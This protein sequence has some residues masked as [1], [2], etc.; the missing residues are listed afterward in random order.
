MSNPASSPLL[1]IIIADELDRESIYRI[2]HDVYARELGQYDPNDAGRLTD[3]LDQSNV[4]LVV[5]DAA[6]VLGFISVTPPGGKLSID[7]YIDRGELP[8]AIDP[9]V[10]EIRILTVC[11][12]NRLDRR[13]IALVL[14]LAALRW[15]E[16]RGGRR[17]V[18]IGR[19]EV[20]GLYRK[21]GLQLLGRCVSRGQVTF[22]IM[23]ATTDELN[24]IVRKHERTFRRAVEQVRWR[25]DSPPFPPAGCFHGGAFFDAI[26][27]HFTDLTRRHQIINADVLDAWFPPSPKVLDQLREHL[28]WL[29]RTS[30]PAACSGLLDAIASARGVPRDSLLPGAGSSDLILRA[31]RHWLSPE[32][33]V[34]IMD[35]TYGEY[36]HVLEH[37]VGCRVQRFRLHRDSNYELDAARF[38]AK[39]RVRFDLIVI[40]NPNSPTG[41]Y[42]DRETM[43]RLVLRVPATTRIWVDEAYIDYLGVGRSIERHAAASENLF[44][45][46]SMSKVYA[47]SGM[48]AAY[49]CGNPCQIAQLRAITPP[50]V[51]GL[52]A[53]VAAVAA[54]SD[55]EY[56]QRKYEQTHQLREDLAEQLRFQLG[57]DVNPGAAN[58][59]LATLPSDGPDAATVESECRAHGLFLR[60]TATMGR[61]MG[62]H[63]LR[64][65]VKSE[66][67]NARMLKILNPAIKTLSPATVGLTLR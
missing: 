65:A 12:A 50:W 51:I 3:D 33:R 44:V 35:P 46:K 36:A 47:L 56:Y 30:P 43:L 39:A 7:K 26:G 9:R 6:R 23:T 13:G 14:M 19:L 55:P 27:D 42:I 60:N 49:L 25:V 34:L 16:A 38:E 18:A 54:L 5:K 11:R 48:R 32:S 61:H 31:L 67:D 37:V 64:I 52:A 59:L 17:V 1:S 4:Y 10:Y 53:Q 22:E 41:T 63:T 29:V 45:C 62:R 57:W 20:L 8:F 21:I 66:P 24:Q 28:P 58:F 15:I 2:R 40:V